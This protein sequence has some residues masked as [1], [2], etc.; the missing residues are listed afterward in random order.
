M[1]NEKTKKP[2]KNDG[3]L[4][5]KEERKKESKEAKKTISEGR[6]LGRAERRDKGLGP[7]AQLPGTW[8]NVS[9]L[10]GR[11]W[12]MIALPFADG[13]FGYRLLVNQYNETL[14][15][16]TVDNNVPNRGLKIKGCGNEYDRKVKKGNGGDQFLAAIDYEQ[17]ITQ[18]AQEDSPDSGLAGKTC[19]TIHHETGLWLYM[20]NHQTNCLNIA[21]SASIPHGN[22]VLAL[23]ESTRHKGAPVIPDVSGLPEG[24]VP[25]IDSPYLAP[26][27]HFTNPLFKNLFNPVT[28]NDLLKA[29]NRGVNI[30]KTTVLDVDTTLESGGIQNIPFVVKQA[31]ASDMKSTFWIQELAEKDINGDPV[32]RLQYSQVIFLDFFQRRDGAPGRIRWPHVSINTLVKDPEGFIDPATDCPV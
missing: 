22:S 12:N 13:P 11:G 6:R 27:K 4:R 19:A 14:K 21:R 20:K 23:G 25:D 1:I 17:S 32:L 30:V 15:F 28:P 3:Q 7:L 31:D 29:A 8:R 18:I 10:P 5:K 9:S 24:V 16:T 26:Y 2:G